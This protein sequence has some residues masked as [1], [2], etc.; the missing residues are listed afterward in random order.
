MSRGSGKGS[1]LRAMARAAALALAAATLTPGPARADQ[2]GPEP[3][4]GMFSPPSGAMILTRELRRSLSDG[5]AII[6]RRSYEIRIV[7]E[8]GGF[9]VDGHL[10]SVD[11]DVP[12]RLMAL[13][14]LERLRSDDGLF[15]IHL[16]TRGLIAEQQG[17]ANIG[18]PQTRQLAESM[19]AKAPL[20]AGQRGDARSFITTLL[21]HPE[22]AGGHWPAELFHPMTGTRSDMRDYAMADGA[23]AHIRVSITAHGDGPGGLLQ[24]FERVI[25]TTASHSPPQESHERWTLSPQGR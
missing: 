20:P 13:A 8:R 16:T 12:P 15:P 24:S 23:P 25:L 14:L 4:A 17:A 11:V 2:L 9:R 19:I 6:T 7:P 5:K 3:G 21:A 18:N 22:I 1:T 10:V